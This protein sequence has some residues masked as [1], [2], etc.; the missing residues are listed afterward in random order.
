MRKI[1]QQMQT[2]IAQRV[3]WSSGNTSVMVDNEGNTFV[4]LHGNIIANISNFG[5]IK[6]SSCGWQ[7]V[8][9]KSRLNAILD[10]FF[11]NCS[12]VQRNFEWLID[13]QKFFDGY[14]ILR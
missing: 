9:T 3:N 4:S 10:V 1:E 14:T 2:A 11:R 6:L 5:D 13:G 12:I 8:T 7:T